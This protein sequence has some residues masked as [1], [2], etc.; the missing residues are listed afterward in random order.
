MS[1]F[2][3]SPVF[4]EKETKLQRMSLCPGLS[5]EPGL[6]PSWVT[7]RHAQFEQVRSSGTLGRCTT[8]TTDPLSN[9]CILIALGKHWRSA[10]FSTCLG[11]ILEKGAMPGFKSKCLF[12][13]VVLW[14]LCW[15]LS[16]PTC[17]MTTPTYD[18][19]SRAGN[20]FSQSLSRSRSWSVFTTG[21]FTITP[22]YTS[23]L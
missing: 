23:C 15:V 18:R 11:P 20:P 21:R 5:P 10:G 14:G 7:H 2:L 9:I 6:L 13:Y 17:V 1:S 19:F 12:S 16:W 3:L 4:G 8:R 22:D